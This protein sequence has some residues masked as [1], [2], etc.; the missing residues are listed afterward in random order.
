MKASLDEYNVVFPVS[1]VNVMLDLI[2]AERL[3]EA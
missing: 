2:E 3:F 1:A